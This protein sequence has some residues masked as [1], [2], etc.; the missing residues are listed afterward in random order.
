[1]TNPDKNA[2]AIKEWNDAQDIFMK[3]R[4]NIEG[5]LT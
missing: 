4:K 2:K 3:E 5:K 1:M